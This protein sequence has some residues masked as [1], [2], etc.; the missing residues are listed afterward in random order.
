[1][2][3][4]Y[5]QGYTGSEKRIG[6]MD[7]EPIAHSP[8]SAGLRSGLSTRAIYLFIATG[9]LQSFKVGKRRLILDREIR[10]FLEQKMS[11]AT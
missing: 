1:M 11:E 7:L 5:E 6:L 3:K 4:F 9:E 10:R 8:T 2:N